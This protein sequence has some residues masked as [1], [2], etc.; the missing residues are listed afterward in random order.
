MRSL[1]TEARPEMEAKCCSRSWCL[2][3]SGIVSQDENEGF[4]E[5]DEGMHPACARGRRWLD[6]YDAV[7]SDG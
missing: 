2:E 1:L 5:I 7:M 6:R 3:R 4:P